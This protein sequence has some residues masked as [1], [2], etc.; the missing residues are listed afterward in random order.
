M[1]TGTCCSWAG[2]GVGFGFPLKPGL[3]S[4]TSFD[5]FK[6]YIMGPGQY[7]VWLSETDPASKVVVKSNTLTI[8]VTGATK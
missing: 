8:T 1:A 3:T 7:T 2:G 6:D 5:L 4:E